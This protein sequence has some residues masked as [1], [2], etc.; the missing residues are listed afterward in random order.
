M[1]VWCFVFSWRFPFTTFFQCMFKILSDNFAPFLFLY[2]FIFLTKFLNS[3]SLKIMSFAIRAYFFQKRTY[4]F[5][6]WCFIHFI[7][8]FFFSI[9]MILTRSKTTKIYATMPRRQY[10]TLRSWITGPPPLITFGKICRT[11]PLLLEPTR[12]L[13]FDY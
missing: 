5:L 6:R 8:W 11:P 12:L 3:W 1:K 9:V 2:G 13:I 10:T 4:L 7:V